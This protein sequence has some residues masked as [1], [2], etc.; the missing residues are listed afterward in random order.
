MRIIA[1]DHFVRSLHAE[2]KLALNNICR[3][4]CKLCERVELL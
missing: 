4:Y 3:L 1:Q 2:V